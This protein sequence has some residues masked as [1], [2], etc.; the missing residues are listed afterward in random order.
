MQILRKNLT[1]IV[2]LVAAVF[3]LGACQMTAIGPQDGKL[4]QD[5]QQ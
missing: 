1:F 2:V 5:Y 3:A 4:F